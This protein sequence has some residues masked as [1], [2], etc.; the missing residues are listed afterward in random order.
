MYGSLYALNHTDIED[1]VYV[2]LTQSEGL[3]MFDIVQVIG[4][5]LWDR[6]K[7]GIDRA[8]RQSL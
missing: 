1:Q 6:L 5:N 4:F 2:C 3:V 8:E 7:A